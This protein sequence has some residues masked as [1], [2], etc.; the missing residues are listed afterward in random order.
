MGGHLSGRK[1]WRNRA[2][3]ET[4]MELDLIQLNRAGC[5][6]PGWQ[7]RWR[8][9]KN[10]E[11]SEWVD[12]RTE[13]DH[14]TITFLTCDTR[15]RQHP[16]LQT[17][18]IDRVRCRFGGNRPFFLCPGGVN[19]GRRVSKLYRPDGCYIMCRFCHKLTFASQSET[20][21]HRAHRRADKIR[22]RLGGESG[23][24]EKPRGMH[25]K[26]FEKLRAAYFEAERKS[27]EKFILR[28]ARCG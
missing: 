22:R 28:S 18:N 2:A 1:R 25:R 14:L 21:R 27:E 23:L 20:E 26:T 15:G 8:C 11:A 9:T 24:Y 12:V 13:L 17:I 6:E 16:T 3:V 4:V 7:G 10:G 19:C 5:L